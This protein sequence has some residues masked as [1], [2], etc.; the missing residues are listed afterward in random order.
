MLYN[1]IRALKTSIK[2]QANTRK[3][4]RLVEFNQEAQLKPYV[5]INTKLIAE[6][7]NDFEMDFFNL[8]NN[9]VFG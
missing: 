2:S 8:I 9:A 7:K 6:A 3:V 4:H 1:Y 5:G